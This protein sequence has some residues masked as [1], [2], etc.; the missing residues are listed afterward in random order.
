MIAAFY[1]ARGWDEF[2]RV[3][4]SLRGELGLLGGAFGDE[5]L[6]RP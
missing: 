6:G 3:P 2:G 1:Q 4:D 5:A